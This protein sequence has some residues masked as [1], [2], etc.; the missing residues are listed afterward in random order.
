MFGSN[1]HEQSAPL[2][3]KP[4][5]R[6]EVVISRY[7]EQGL[8]V[9]LSLIPHEFHVTI[10]NKGKKLVV[11]PKHRERTRVFNVPNVGRCDHT[12]LHH[13]V[14]NYTSSLADVTIFMVASALDDSKFHKSR[15]LMAVLKAV[16]TSYSSAFPI[17]YFK[18]LDEL[19]NFNVKKYTATNKENRD[20]N[21][22]S[23]TLLC[24]IR[25]FGKWYETVLE[26]YDVPSPIP[27]NYNG[28]F[29]VEKKHIKQRPLKLYKHL[30][31][32]VD[33]SSNPEAGHYME[34]VWTS[35]F[36]PYPEYCLRSY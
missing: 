17:K 15:K 36:Y 23:E 9:L 19:Y 26:G 21:P 4:P 32:F 25:P 35:L 31:S 28:I 29:A 12:Y 3:Y 27:I 10:Y 16:S 20:L 34:R 24:P 11:P 2:P 6:V 13:I 33:S 1:I 7:N 14:E 18:T 8:D 30:I 5:R 22:Q